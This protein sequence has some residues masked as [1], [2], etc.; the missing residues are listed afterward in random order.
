MTDVQIESISKLI[1]D[2]MDFEHS[3]LNKTGFSNNPNLEI[4]YNINDTVSLKTGTDIINVNISQIKGL[5]NELRQQ[6]KHSKEPIQ[7]NS[8]L[9]ELKELTNGQ[10]EMSEEY[11]SNMLYARQVLSGYGFY[12]K[13]LI[14]ISKLFYSGYTLKYLNKHYLNHEEF[15]KGLLSELP[16][17]ISI[18]DELRK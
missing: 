8:S 17:F 6:E 10:Y 16:G 9:L 2:L 15:T 3:I 1:S 13:R 5:V 18:K 4:E 14:E 7:N 12:K 11:F